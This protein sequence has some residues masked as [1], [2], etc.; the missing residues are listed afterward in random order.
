ME[1]ENAMEMENEK[2]R[3]IPWEAPPERKSGQSAGNG[4]RSPVGTGGF[5]FFS[6][7]RVAI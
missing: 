5:F 2:Y 6:L 3:A 4:R 7:I 1:K